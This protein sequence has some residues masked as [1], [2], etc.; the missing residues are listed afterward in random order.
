M[1]NPN[2]GRDAAI[3]RR[4]ALSAGKAALPP[5]AERTRSGFRDASLPGTQPAVAGP[6]PV[7]SAT[8][9][10][11]LP[12]RLT[13]HAISGRE[14]SIERRRMLAAGK[15]ALISGIAPRPPEA[16]D[17]PASNPAQFT[18]P[19]ARVTGSRVSRGQQVTG[20]DRGTQRSVSGTPHID[21]KAAHAAFACSPKVGQARTAAG[22]TVTGTLVRSAVRITGDERGDQSTITG[23]VDPRPADD[24]TARQSQ[25][26]AVAQFHRQANPHGAVTFGGNLGRSA[27]N[28]GSRNRTNTATLEATESGTV[29]TGSA[30]GRSLR[31]TGDEAG[32]CRPVSGSQ[33]LA[34]ARLATACGGIGGGTAPAAQLG[35]ARPDPV[36]LSKVAVSASHGGQ[37]ITGIDVENHAR[38][39]GDAPSVC[40]TPTGSQYQALPAPAP[41][42]AAPKSA[43][44]KSATARRMLARALPVTGNTTA[45]TETVSGLNRGADRNITGTPYFAETA[46]AETTPNS[47]AVIDAKFSI[48][49]PQRAAQI[50]NT[51]A[52][53]ESGRIT[54][55]FAV[56]T[57][58]VTGNVEF[59]AR[60]RTA[61]A[62]DAKPAHTRIS[63]EGSSTGRAITGDSWS[64]ANRVTGTEGAFAANRNQTERGE[65]AKAFAGATA[66]KAQVQHEEPKQLVTGMFGYFSKTG[67][68]VTLSG[69]AQ[70]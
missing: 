48:S 7:T 22:L 18:P 8:Q 47:V 38:V 42:S 26:T 23:K 52:A 31:V 54:G 20:D 67:A 60:R 37:R 17:A 50:R 66:F 63:G 2:S 46:A 40:A 32:A 41:E 59:A 15:T 65:K 43:A 68:R 3:A 56:G 70:S 14:A 51:G 33:Y 24:L 1:A 16:T 35:T 49:T 25:G 19:A 10:P 44:A 61:V 64:N 9:A 39:T 29:I 69:G 62:N 13:S 12:T 58:K 45:A 36:T 4:R 28:V 57:G 27:Q 6:Q 11:A 34:P 55:S 21:A 53:D 5:P 30:I